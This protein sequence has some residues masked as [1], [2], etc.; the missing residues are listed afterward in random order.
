MFMS[1]MLGSPSKFSGMFKPRQK[2]LEV[3]TF[4]KSFSR[5]QQDKTA[6]KIY[7][8]REKNKVL[9]RQPKGFGFSFLSL[10]ISREEIK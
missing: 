2:R 6:Q 1:L 8:T 9:K 3:L 5:T 7:L 10:F 4:Q